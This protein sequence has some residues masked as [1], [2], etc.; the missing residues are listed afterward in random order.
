MGIKYYLEGFLNDWIENL[1]LVDYKSDVDFDYANEENDR[2]WVELIDDEG[3][4]FFITI[5]LNGVEDTTVDLNANNEHY[6]IL[7]DVSICDSIRKLL[8]KYAM[9]KG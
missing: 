7:T 4:E 6:K 9:K 3:Y 2:Y 1:N 5:P 8:E